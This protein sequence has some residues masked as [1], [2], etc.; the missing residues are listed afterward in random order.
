M[1]DQQSM[2]LEAAYSEYL[3]SGKEE[4]L[5]RVVEAGRRLVF[6]F[7]RIYTGGTG[8]DVVQAGMEGLLKAVHRYRADQGASFVTYAGHCVMGE[9]RHYIRRESAYYRPGC[10]KDLQYRVDRYV[11][12]VLKETGEPPALSEVAAALNVKEEGVLQ[13]MRAGLV[14]LDD[15]DVKKIRVGKYESFRLPI[16]DRL[17]LEQGLQRLN[18]IQKRVIYYL[19]YRDMTQ[20]Q[21]AQKLGI[22]QRKVSRVLHKSLEQMAREVKY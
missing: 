21:A 10:I 6:H 22:S 4:D 9:I 1:F 14:S 20:Q 2:D 16:E 12:K 15:V 19:F 3:G 5:E 18:D 17:L 7:A 11:E 13:V 8:D